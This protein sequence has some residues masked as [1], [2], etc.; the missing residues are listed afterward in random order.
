MYKVRA[1]KHLGQHFLKDENN[2]R[3]SMDKKTEE[4]M[5]TERR[6]NKHIIFGALV[7]YIRLLYHAVSEFM[8]IANLEGVLGNQAASSIPYRFIIESKGQHFVVEFLQLSLNSFYAYVNGVFNGKILLKM[9]QLAG[10]CTKNLV[11][12]R[13]SGIYGPGRERLI[14]M[15]VSKGLEVQ[16]SPPFYTNRI[17]RDDAAAALHHLLEIDKPQSLY[18]ATDN[19]PAPRFEVV[20]WLAKAQGKPAPIPLVDEQASCGKRVNNQRLRD[21]GF[22][23]TYPDYRAGYGAVL[24]QRT[25]DS[26]K[27]V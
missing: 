24:A 2:L 13:I 9:E 11:A 21:S 5:F 10:S 20:E 18:V 17:H 27:A 19:Q 23:L 7:E 16:Q 25:N 1:K 12:V 26:S 14:R 6:V 4:Y 15:A 8:V 22:N 3:E